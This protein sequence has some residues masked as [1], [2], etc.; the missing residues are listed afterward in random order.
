M[1]ASCTRWSL[2]SAVSATTDTA[3]TRAKIPDE[4]LARIVCPTLVLLGAEEMIYNPA[5]A[6]SRAHRTIARVETEVIP[7]VGHL[8]GLE[9]PDL[10]NRRVVTFLA[11]ATRVPQVA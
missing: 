11:G 10:V 1:N 2:A 5:Q 9:R 3:S 6:A 7:E 8:L 4:E